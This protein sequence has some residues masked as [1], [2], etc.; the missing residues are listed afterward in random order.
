MSDALRPGMEAPLRHSS[1][2]SSFSVDGDVIARQ[3][4]V[5]EGRVTGN[6]A[7]PDHALTIAPGGRVEG[8]VFA[9][10]VTVA[11]T[12]VGDITATTRI[13]V[14][15]RGSVDGEMTSPRLLVEDGAIVRA[16]VDTRRT[17]SAVKVAQYRLEKRMADQP[18]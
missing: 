4:L 15:E 16:K 10:A 7:L 17:E 6:I 18:A 3:D 9:R 12:F 2:G 11:G 1:F 8:S 14:V 5:V 13:Q